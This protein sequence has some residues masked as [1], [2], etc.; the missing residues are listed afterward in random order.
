MCLGAACKVEKK[1]EEQENDNPLLI[2]Y[3]ELVV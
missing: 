2:E 1:T 3:L